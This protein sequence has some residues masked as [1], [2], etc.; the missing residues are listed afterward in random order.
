MLAK[1]TVGYCIV[2][3]CSENIHSQIWSAV[4]ETG[5]FLF[6]LIGFP[7]QDLKFLGPFWNARGFHVG[8]ESLEDQQLEAWGDFNLLQ[9]VGQLVVQLRTPTMVHFRESKTPHPLLAKPH[10]QG[11]SEPLGESWEAL[12]S[13][14]L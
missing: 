11:N 1:K 9:G 4:D 3:G 5:S 7:S 6:H 14:N 12:G 8:K 13:D 2:W 10:Q